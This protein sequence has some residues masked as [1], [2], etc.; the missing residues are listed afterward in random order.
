MSPTSG[1]TDRPSYCA[2]CWLH[3]DSGE[4]GAEN[5]VNAGLDRLVRPD[6]GAQAGVGV[7]VPEKWQEEVH[8]M[9]IDA[10]EEHRQG[11]VQQ[12]EEKIAES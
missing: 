6:G 1:R 7:L 9:D 3:V 4:D 11:Q 5:G 2:H 8:H 10:A 12:Y